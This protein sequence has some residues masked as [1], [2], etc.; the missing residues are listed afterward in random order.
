MRGVEQGSAA[1]SGA[2]ACFQRVLTALVLVSPLAHS[3]CLASVL[4]LSLQ[5]ESLLHGGLAS[6]LLLSLQ[7]E[8]LLLASLLLLSLQLG[9]PLDGGLA[10]VLLLSL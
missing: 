2:H 8:S 10:S 1:R 9:S 7:P 3:W 4:L 5:P 6:V